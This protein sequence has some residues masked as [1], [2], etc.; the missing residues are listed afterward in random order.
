MTERDKLE[1]IAG[2]ACSNIKCR[3]CPIRKECDHIV[4]DLRITGPAFALTEEFRAA[5]R[6]KLAEMDKGQDNSIID[7]QPDRVTLHRVSDGQTESVEITQAQYDA[8][9]DMVKAMKEAGK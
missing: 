6:A 1:K 5:A 9:F 2:G 8:I 4:Y 3:E 7:T